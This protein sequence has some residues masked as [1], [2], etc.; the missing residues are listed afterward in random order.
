MDK[1]AYFDDKVLTCLLCWVVLYFCKCTD[2]LSSWIPVLGEMCVYV[3]LA[4][5][6]RSADEELNPD[7]LAC[8]RAVSDRNQGEGLGMLL[9]SPE[10]CVTW[11]YGVSG[12]CTLVC[13]WRLRKNG[14][15][16]LA[17]IARVERHVGLKGRPVKWHE[18]SLKVVY[19]YTTDFI[20][21]LLT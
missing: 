2:G 12:S 1:S 5:Y 3:H 14:I 20:F 18:N 19:N 16:Q 17:G 6:P 15:I 9:A 21:I 7:G 13:V 8:R 10:L 11:S 4:W